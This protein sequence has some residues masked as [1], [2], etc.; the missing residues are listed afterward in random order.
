M[1]GRGLRSDAVRLGARMG[2]VGCLSLVAFGVSAGSALGQGYTAYVTS[3]PNGNNTVTPISTAT[4]S[5]GTPISVGGWPFG[6]AITPNGETA[7][8][9]IDSY[10]TV[11]PIT[12]A[13]R[14]LGSQIPVGGIPVGV[15]ITP[16]GNTAYV[17]T[18][19][20]GVTPIS[21]A[22]NTPGPPIPVGSAPWAIA[23]TPNGET[24][25]VTNEDDDTVTPI[26]TA[27]NTPGTPIPVGIDPL[28][29]AITP[30]GETAYVANNGSG[31]VTP[32]SIATNTP[33]SP[34]AIG[35]DTG[36][37]GIAITP[38]G[39]TAYVADVT[40]A[41]VTPITIATNTPGTPIPV[42]PYPTWIA[43]GPEYAGRATSTLLGCSPQRVV[44]DQPTSCNVTVTDTGTGTPVTPT[45]AISFDSDSPGTFSVSQCTLSG[46][47]ASASCQVT[48]TPTAVA[49]GQ[50]ALTATFSG[51]YA[52]TGS[53]GQTI[54][55]V[56][57]RATRTRTHCRPR[58]MG[59]ETST[60]CMA[61]VRDR[62]RGAA[63]TPTGFVTFA[64]N[65][66]G[67][68]TGSPCILSIIGGVSSC[69][70]TYT[71]AT[72]GLHELTATYSGDSTHAGS[73]SR[74]I[75]RVRCARG[76][77]RS[78]SRRGC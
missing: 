42:G 44:I 62:G 26:A 39:L 40:A 48:Y 24:A 30:D 37:R 18:C 4:N 28:G 56:A 3:G 22:T 70:V 76:G 10:G 17:T 41:A 14:T 59:V 12:L 74:T 77:P 36:P 55:A 32:I 75:L 49:S 64:S 34:I 25:Y 1:R 57:L 38:N 6:I 23:I 21:L 46:T 66:P 51:D 2:L 61:V 54:L 72:A 33:G 16:N 69:Q 43:I 67:A 68:F 5:A 52:H 15:A 27:T 71:P 9:T 7:Y 63:V 20:A 65:R 47:G 19:G 58:T 31:T 29:V 35:P 78:P 60:V 8:V 73:R 13:S 53:S 45:G 50:H 11:T